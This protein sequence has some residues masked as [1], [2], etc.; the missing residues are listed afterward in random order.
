M[1]NHILFCFRYHTIK[2]G[3]ATV[4]YKAVASRTQSKTRNQCLTKEKINKYFQ[5]LEEEALSSDDDEFVNFL[6]SL[7][8]FNSLG[9]LIS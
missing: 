9:T 8:C 3:K 7:Q 2:I 6:H 1:N 4:P 5:Y